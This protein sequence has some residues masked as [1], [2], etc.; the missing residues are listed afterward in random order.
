MKP[1][2]KGQ[3]DTWKCLGRRE[4]E[5]GLLE[6]RAWSLRKLNKEAANLRAWSRLEFKGPIQKMERNK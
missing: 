5:E 4:R 2:T 6:G 3:E 1:D